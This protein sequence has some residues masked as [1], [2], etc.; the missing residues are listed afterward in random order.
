MPKTERKL[1]HEEFTLRAIKKLRGKYKSIHSNYSGFNQAF[2]LYFDEDPV[3]A[4]NNL[5]AEGK[6]D[7]HPTKGGVRLYLPG[8][9]VTSRKEPEVILAAIIG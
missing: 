9:M 7:I 5:A 4:V 8:E 3:E 2:R 6:I 1:S